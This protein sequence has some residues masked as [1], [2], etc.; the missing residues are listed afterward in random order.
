MYALNIHIVIVSSKQISD[1][2]DYSKIVYLLKV[3]E[4]RYFYL[5]EITLQMSNAIEN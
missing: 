1:D 2:P 4:L 3:L 5:L